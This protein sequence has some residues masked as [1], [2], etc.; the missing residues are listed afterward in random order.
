MLV[1]LVP[2]AFSEASYWWW[3]INL[4]V[5]N[6]VGLTD[7]LIIAAGRQLSYIASLVVAG[8][9]L[10]WA[11]RVMRKDPRELHGLLRAVSILTALALAIPLAWWISV[12]VMRP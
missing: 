2:L 8:A 12:M 9:G 3:R 10:V 4:P 11:V 5:R 6:N 7:A 1:G